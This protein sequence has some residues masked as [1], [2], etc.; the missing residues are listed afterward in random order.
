MNTKYLNVPFLFILFSLPLFLFAKESPF[1]SLLQAEEQL[2][3]SDKLNDFLLSP[4]PKLYGHDEFFRNV[5]KSHSDEF[6]NTREDKAM[7]EF[8]QK[9]LEFREW[10]LTQLHKGVSDLSFKYLLGYEF[11]VKE[12]ILYYMGLK[13]NEKA[14]RAMNQIEAEAYALQGTIARFGLS[15]QVTI[16]QLVQMR[17]SSLIYESAYN[18]FQR[19]FYKALVMV[20][21]PER[22][23][24][25][26]TFREIQKKILNEIRK[27]RAENLLSTL[28][29]VE[30]QK[31]E[32]K[33]VVVTPEGTIVPLTG[34]QNVIFY[35]NSK[36]NLG[37]FS[38]RQRVIDWVDA[39]LGYFSLQNRKTDYDIAQ[40]F[41]IP[42]EYSPRWPSL[43]AEI[44]FRDG[45]K[46]QISE[47][48]FSK[49]MNAL[50]LPG[51]LDLFSGNVYGKRFV[52]E[53]SKR[54]ALLGDLDQ[55]VSDS[56]IND[57][58]VL[59]KNIEQRIASL[60][61]QNTDLRY[62]LT[63]SIRSEHNVLETH[64]FN[65][66][67]WAG[68]SVH[69]DIWR[70]KSTIAKKIGGTHYWSLNLSHSEKKDVAKEED[71]LKT[72]KRQ[73]KKEKKLNTQR[74]SSRFTKRNKILTPIALWAGGAA[75]ALSLL[76]TGMAY[77]RDSLL[78]IDLNFLDSIDISLPNGGSQ[79]SN[80]WNMKS[81]NS[82]YIVPEGHG[83]GEKK[84]V[85]TVD[86]VKE[87][88]SIP[89][90][91]NILDEGNL[92]KDVLL[93]NNPY[94]EPS[95]VQHIKMPSS[96]AHVSSSDIIVT[97]YLK[98]T[99]SN[100]RYGILSFEGYRLV[101]L[102]V[103][104]QIGSG[105]KDLPRSIYKAY[106]VPNSGLTYIEVESDVKITSYT[107]YYVKDERPI[108][109]N[110]SFEN[111]NKAALG[112]ISE[113][114]NNLGATELSQNINAHISKPSALD[115]N[116]L[117]TIY[118]SSG[119][120]TYSEVSKTKTSWFSWPSNNQQSSHQT[121]YFR[122]YERYL[123]NGSLYYQCTGSNSLL[124]DS[125]NLYSNL[126][127]SSFEAMAVHGF[128]YESEGIVYSNQGHRHT[129]VTNR[130]KE[131][132]Y[133]Y[134]DATPVNMD[135]K[136]LNKQ[137]PAEKTPQE[138][139]QSR[140]PLEMIGFLVGSGQKKQTSNEKSEQKLKPKKI[141]NK[142]EIEEDRVRILKQLQSSLEDMSKL[143]E[144]EA[145]DNSFFRNQVNRL[146]QEPGLNVLGYTTIIIELLEK[147]INP[148]LALK[149]LIAKELQMGQLHLIGSSTNHPRIEEIRRIA[150]ERI[151]EKG[152]VEFAIRSI[153]ETNK[154]K[155]ELLLQNVQQEL[156][157]KGHSPLSFYL[158]AEWNGK[159][160]GLS[161]A[162][163]NIDYGFLVSQPSQE[164]K[165]PSMK[166]A[167]EA[168]S[169]TLYLEAL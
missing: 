46:V 51:S 147:K 130:D 70:L 67:R 105:V 123:L 132:E 24:Q 92:P 164:V 9:G 101:N 116:D 69:S 145:Q 112:K 23:P 8:A 87:G 66:I 158:E 106:E 47:S 13:K 75:T 133:V 146:A 29:Y 11:F 44:Y 22:S 103:G 139:L 17:F 56:N 59:L 143:A 36:L 156:M 118:N 163:L 120:Y 93:D 115:L 149:I 161:T 155:I 113:E 97:S 77:W 114:L 65:N 26:L 14:H 72:N 129:L 76:Y 49:W 78:D 99:G 136:H 134:L 128:R 20:D 55:I 152:S 154:N 5:S 153:L 19:E 41:Y 73:E 42:Q 166:T 162:L 126:T 6:E 30:T 84:I 40:D 2:L 117:A 21:I 74:T 16:P 83:D 35:N 62:S 95:S 18:Y 148:E 121:N 157:T 138:P 27:A 81:D 137:N 142:I 63:E 39:K 169:C 43:I 53:A 159:I 86:R 48:D 151:Q 61:P 168:E 7:V 52:L 141:K 107:A 10:Y 3:N 45:N 165:T 57:V 89:E 34:V 60:S 110:K 12:R 104:I 31:H 80:Y 108:L 127:N 109:R 38:S 94:S 125:I 124:I 58:A 131:R 119:F 33:A 85:F 135:S 71:L 140:N 150:K 160:Q 90:Y 1:Q 50:K 37:K 88:H 91:F 144:A 79:S 102:S 15:P 25:P 64:F 111:L 122:E 68:W 167:L 28:T 4:K 100:N 82:H 54:D 32:P 98:M 96:V